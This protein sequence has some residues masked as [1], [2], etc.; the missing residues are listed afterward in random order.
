M[1][2]KSEE[3]HN[4]W[5]DD[6]LER[7][8]DARYL[9]N[10]L[11]GRYA[12]KKTEPGFVLAINSDWGYGK[13]FMLERWKK[14]V[15]FEG[16]PAVFFDAWQN[17]FTDDPLLAF[18]AE[19][20]SGLKEYFKHIPAGDKIKTAAIAAVRKLYKPVLTVLASAAAKHLVGMS[21]QH[22][23]QLFSGNVGDDNDNDSS[24]ENAAG[25]K[26][27][28][29]KLKKAITKALEEHN[30]IK[31]SISDFKTKLTILINALERVSGVQ[32]PLII[33]VD[34]LDRC[35]PDYAIELLEGIKHLFG[36]PGVFFIVATNIHQLG[37]SVKAVYGAGFDG[38][39]YLKRFFDLQYS[40]REPSNRQ[41]SNLLFSKM[42][43]PELG[44]LV[45]GLGNVNIM[46]DQRNFGQ[47][48]IEMLS[49]VLE[50]HAGAFE[51]G[52]RDQLQIA[53]ILEA[54]FISL[55]G[56]QIHVFFLIFLVVVYQQ[57]P[58]IYG[59]IAKTRS[60]SEQTGFSKLDKSNGR[61]VIAVESYSSEG[62]P[63]VNTHTMIDISKVY[64]S[65]MNITTRDYSEMPPHSY[66]FPNN[67]IFDL[68]GKSEG[69]FFWPEYL[70]Y[71]ELVQH[72]GGFVRK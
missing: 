42:E 65:L 71:F 61:G 69:K 26:E 46:S 25:F 62:K 48:S 50:K 58:V 60:L 55:Q 49:F 14:Q 44:K 45:H 70:D 1:S 34:E 39:R 11:V 40:L 53:T 51:L 21:A 52:L 66:D 72:A 67:L 23:Q 47:T 57:D 15:L 13:S 18:I 31:K 35:R 32:L 10:Y 17:D 29:E 59:K 28:E 4:I 3:H 20:D 22:T 12:A 64:F 56:K 19:F 36:V 37:E 5:Q 7:E 30:T 33:F 41:F 24:S 8:E 63:F 43:C 38:Q 6:V 27:T 16:H 68:K 2:E 54:V 9:Q